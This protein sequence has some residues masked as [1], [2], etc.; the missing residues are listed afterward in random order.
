MDPARRHP[1]PA[2][3]HR[4]RAAAGVAV[5]HRARRPAARL[6]AGRPGHAGGDDPRA[7]HAQ[8]ALRGRLVHPA[9]A[10]RRGWS[11]PRSTSRCSI[12]LRDALAAELDET[13][14][15]E[16][17][18]QEFEHLVNAAPSGPRHEPWRRTSGM[19]RARGRRSLAAVRELWQA[20]DEIAAQRDVTPG[21]IIPD[22]AI[23]EAANALPRDRAVAARA[24]GLQ[25]PGRRTLRRPV[26]RRAPRAPGRCPTTSCR[27]WP[28]GTTGRR[29][30][31]PGPTG[32]GGGGAAEHRPHR[33]QRARAHELNVPVENLLTPDYVRRVMWEPPDADERDL[34]DA[35]ADRLRALGAREWQVEL[36]TD[37]LVEGDRHGRGDRGGA[38]ARVRGPEGRRA[39]GP[40]AV[41]VRA[42]WRHAS[43]AGLTP[44][45]EPG[46]PATWCR[47]PRA[48]RRGRPR[49][50][51]TAG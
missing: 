9:A 4:A 24:Q 44:P 48:A 12:E 28:R 43:G 51:R 35:V 6:P 36:T 41:A 2:L 49:A 7:P 20:R 38:G 27:P 45:R 21:R 14:K 15:T 26:G 19:H 25:G 8:G 16:W 13:G 10:R 46:P 17:A 1:G 40:A 3:P 29:R 11:T 34:S 42:P 5:R 22:S 32:P 23:V 37:L 39:G 31:V 50:S 30:P 18:R 33:A 47:C